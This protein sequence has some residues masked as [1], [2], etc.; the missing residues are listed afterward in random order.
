MS[1]EKNNQSSTSNKKWSD[2]TKKEKNRAILN[3]SIIGFA[4]FIIFSMIVMS[5][6][7]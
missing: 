2:F 7:I 6:T 1:L 3:L 5:I 4:I